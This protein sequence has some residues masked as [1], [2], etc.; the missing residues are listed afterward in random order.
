MANFNEKSNQAETG[1]FPY[2]LDLR[3]F[4]DGIAR[5]ILEKYRHVKGNLY[6]DKGFNIKLP[7]GLYVEGDLNLSGSFIQALPKGLTVCG[8]LDLSRTLFVR[9]LPE[10]LSVGGDLRIVDS[11]LDGLALPENISI[12]GRIIDSSYFANSGR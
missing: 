6:V 7:E 10:D 1:V 11:S 8:S 3:G 9:T 2:D 12:G 5:F 4:P